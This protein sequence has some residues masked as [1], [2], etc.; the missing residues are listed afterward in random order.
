MEKIKQIRQNF[1][2]AVTNGRRS[3]SG[4]IVLGH[5]DTLTNLFSG[6][7]LVEPLKFGLESSSSVISTNINSPATYLEVQNNSA[8]D[9]TNDA[10]GSILA[11]A[12]GDSSTPNISFTPKFNN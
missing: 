5:Y 1:P 2:N 9:V 10:S 4:K 3:G 6:S 7:A 11:D 12:E 8:S